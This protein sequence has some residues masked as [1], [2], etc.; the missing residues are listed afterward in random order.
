MN[1]V[2]QI[3]ASDERVTEKELF[4]RGHVKAKRQSNLSR[5]AYCLK[6]QLNYEQFGYWENKWR[7]QN[8]ASK[9]I[10]VHFNMP[11]KTNHTPRAETLCTLMLRSGHELKIHDRSILPVICSLW[12]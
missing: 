4:W 6:H 1:K 12:G 9:L 7:R 10:P 8:G 3:T 5:K 2:L 11:V